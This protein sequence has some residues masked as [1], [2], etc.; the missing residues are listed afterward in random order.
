MTDKIGETIMLHTFPTH[1]KA[2]Y[3]KKCKD[4]PAFTES[5]DILMP[6]VG[7]NL[8]SNALLWGMEKSFYIDFIAPVTKE[9]MVCSDLEGILLG[10]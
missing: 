1:I 2:F 3:M 7:K 4:D 6:N 10:C 9:R 8:S 5:V